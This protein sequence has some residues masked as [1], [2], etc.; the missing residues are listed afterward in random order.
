MTVKHLLPSLVIVFTLIIPEPISLGVPA[1]SPPFVRNEVNRPF[2]GWVDFNNATNIITNLTEP[3]A[4]N[5][6][7]YHS[8]GTVLDTTLWLTSPFKDR[9]GHTMNYG[10]LIDADSN[11]K[12][13]WGGADYIAK[14]TENHKIWYS[15][16]AE[17]TQ[18]GQVKVISNGS[19]TNNDLF[20]SRLSSVHLPVD[21]ST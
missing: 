20:D 4:L 11:S 12:T 2:T 15:I 14:V 6:T 9:P 17:M 8:T 21:L 13:G 7:T 18:S 19:K 16:I 10:I 1:S 3:S 5:S